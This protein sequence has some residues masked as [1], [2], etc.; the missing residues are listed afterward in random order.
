MSII[1][2]ILENA[3]S[4]HP[5]RLCGHSEAD[6]CKWSDTARAIPWHVSWHPI[7]WEEPRNYANCAASTFSSADLEC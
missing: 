5:C 6:Q 4:Q 1:D 2:A 7:D 3:R